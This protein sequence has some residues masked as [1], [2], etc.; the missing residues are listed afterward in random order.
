MKK[1]DTIREEVKKSKKKVLKEIEKEESLQE[2]P[3]EKPQKETPP[4]ENQIEIKRPL[5]RRILRQVLKTLFIRIPVVLA[6]LILLVLVVLKAYLTPE[7][8]ESLLVHNFNNQSN[9]T[10]T[11]KVKEFSPYGGFVFE[12]II[13]RN[14]AEFDKT[15]FISMKRLAVKYHFFRFFTGSVNIPEVGIYSPH[16][17]LVEKK[18]V[19]NAARLMR[20]SAPSEEKKEEPEKEEKSGLGPSKISLPVSVDLLFN[21]ILDDLRVYTKGSAFRS[22]LEGLS[23]STKVVVPPTKEIPLSLEAVTLLDTMDIKLNPAEEL[24]VSF[25]SADAQVSPPLLMSWKLGYEKGDRNRPRFNSSFKFGTYK[26]PVRFKGTYLAPLTFLVSY[27]LYYSP[28]EDRLN[29]DH[30]G[31]SFGGKKWIDLTG[32]IARATGNQQIDLRMRESLIDLRALYPYYLSLTKDRNTRFNGTISLYPLNVKGT[33]SNLDVDGELN[34][35]NIYVKLAQ[36]GVEASLPLHNLRI[37]REDAR[38]RYKG[39][40]RLQDSAYLLCPQGQQVR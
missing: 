32:N 11:L 18:G 13:I 21:F 23:F 3:Q 30:L 22:S 4:S 5:W 26:T 34:M 14:G 37:R 35:R 17:Y 1:K 28:L 24:D 16:I 9:G 20:E 10:I 12:D 15:V 40:G 2:E 38:Q 7:R 36:Q 39:A 19:W 25:Y 31:V 33:L 27:N 6:M 29:L 8:V